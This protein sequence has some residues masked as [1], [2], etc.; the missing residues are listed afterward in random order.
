MKVLYWIFL[1]VLVIGGLNW[2]LVGWLDLN[3]VTKIF[4]DVTTMTA[5][6]DGVQ[7]AVTT[8][9]KFAMMTYTLVGI[10]ALWVLIANLIG[11]KKK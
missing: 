8:L 4:A 11:Y 9:N 6:A 10:S 3:L 2:A 5:G 7:T 1:I